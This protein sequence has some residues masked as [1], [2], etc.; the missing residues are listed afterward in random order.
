[1]NRGECESVSPAAGNNSHIMPHVVDV[2]PEQCCLD[3]VQI[4]CLWIDTWIEASK[5]W[6]I[7]NMNQAAFSLINQ[8]EGIQITSQAFM[9]TQHKDVKR[10][11]TLA[12]FGV[13][14]WPG[15]TLRRHDYKVQVVFINY[16]CDR[17]VGVHVC[18]VRLLDAGPVSTWCSAPATPE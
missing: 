12:S 14:M 17:H 9:Q 16:S 4:C 15:D 2:T 3:W 1:M 11:D 5:D 8:S 7:D 13:G 18:A 10:R 6:K